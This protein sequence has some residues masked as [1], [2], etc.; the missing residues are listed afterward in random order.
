RGAEASTEWITAQEIGEHIVH[1]LEG[2]LPT[3]GETLYELRNRARR[4][5]GNHLI[6]PRVREGAYR[7]SA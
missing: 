1:L 5:H 3:A 6:P 2:S 7:G 4:P